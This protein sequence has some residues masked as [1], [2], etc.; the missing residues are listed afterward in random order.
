LE[1]IFLEHIDSKL[2]V[3]GKL[4]YNCFHIYT[5]TLQIRVK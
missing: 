1:N 3:T 5:F 2:D 4:E